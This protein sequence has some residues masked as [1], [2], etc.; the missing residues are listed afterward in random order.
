MSNWNSGWRR[1]VDWDSY[2]KC[3]LYKNKHILPLTYKEQIEMPMHLQNE[4]YWDEIARIDAEIDS[5]NRID[6]K[7]FDYN[8]SAQKAFDDW[9]KL[10]QS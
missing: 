8:N 7:P 9:W 1:L 2:N 3:Y 10:V 4:Y 6:S 5:D